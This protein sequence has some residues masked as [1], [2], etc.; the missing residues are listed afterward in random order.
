MQSHTT[1]HSTIVSETGGRIPVFFRGKDIVPSTL[2]IM[3]PSHTLTVLLS[4][5]CY[6]LQHHRFFT[7]WPKIRKSKNPKIRKSENPKICGYNLGLRFQSVYT[8]PFFADVGDRAHT[9]F[10]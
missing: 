3:G 6:F 7:S 9:P 10:L 2:S 4:L 1:Y 8:M 5:C